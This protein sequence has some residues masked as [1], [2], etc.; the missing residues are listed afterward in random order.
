VTLFL[1][2]Q[3]DYYKKARGCARDSHPIFFYNCA[4]KKYFNHISS[5]DKC[6]AIF[7]HIV[8]SKNKKEKIHFQILKQMQHIA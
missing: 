5:R 1:A 4:Q 7:M 6:V 2:L 3:S 8:E